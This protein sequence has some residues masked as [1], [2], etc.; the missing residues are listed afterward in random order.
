VAS[1]QIDRTK[2]RGKKSDRTWL[3]VFIDEQIKDSV[4]ETKT[5]GEKEV[6]TTKTSIVPEK[7]AALVKANGLGMEKI[8]AQ[9]EA[10]Q[11]GAVGRARMILTGCLKRKIINDGKLFDVD[12]DEVELDSEY[13][14]SITPAPKEETAKTETAE[15]A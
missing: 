4:T 15:A 13:V 8:L 12:G 2:Y 11:N 9:V 7:L 3:A 6:N 1:I 5:I 14:A 10:G